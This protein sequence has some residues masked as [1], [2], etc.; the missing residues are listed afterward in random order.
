MCDR[1]VDTII[2][3]ARRKKAL[4][5]MSGGVD[6]SVA[7]ALLQEQGFEV[8]G[9]FFHFWKE[10]GS[11]TKENACCSL[12]AKRD[13]RAVAD[14][15]GIP[16]YTINVA[17]VFKQ[18]VVD[19]FIQAYACGETPNP[20]VAC[21]RSVKHA[22][23]MRT[24]LQLGADVVATGHYARVQKRGREWQ[25][26]RGQDKLKDQSYFLFHLDQRSLARTVFP[27]GKL[28]KSQVRSL[29]KQFNL[30]VFN[31][32]ESQDICFIADSVGSFLERNLALKSGDIVDSKGKIVGRHAGLPGFTIG[33]RK[34]L[35]VG[36]RGPYFVVGK[37]AIKNQLLVTNNQND[38][39]LLMAGVAVKGV[40]WVGK[41][42]LPVR[43]WVETRYHNQPA[44]AIIKQTGPRSVAVVFR[45]P[46]RA[47]PAGQFAVFY[48][49][50][51]KVLGGGVIHKPISKN[52]ANN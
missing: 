2:M 48:S 51:G 36:G 44:Y 49:K 46:Q 11:G 37:N 17:K 24:A 30:P 18:S 22:A 45:S 32:Q 34:G 6:S 16:L 43:A 13:A 25:L 47:V 10:P 26:L 38:P 29:A 41:V 33:Q 4:V 12:E 5:A 3:Q 27:L 50:N 23:L 14:K 9:V 28:Q 19:P 15:L 42:K 21:N 20:C 39:R 35:N 52:Y 1:V 31:K 40:S 8:I 7:A